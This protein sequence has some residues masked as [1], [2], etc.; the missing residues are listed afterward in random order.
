LLGSAAS[1]KCESK[2][3]ISNSCGLSCFNSQGMAEVER[4]TIIPNY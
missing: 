1:L 2:T 4:I 3:A